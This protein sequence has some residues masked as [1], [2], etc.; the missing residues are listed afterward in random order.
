MPSRCSIQHISIS[1]RPRSGH[2]TE[3]CQSSSQF[4]RQVLLKNVLT[5]RQM[6]SSPTPVRSCL[7]SCILGL[8]IM[9]TKNFQMSKLGLKKEEEPDIKLPTFTGSYINQSNSRKTSISVSSTMLKPSTVWIITNCGKFLKRWEYQPI[10]PVS[11]ETYMQVKKQQLEL[12]ME[13]LIGS[14]LK[15]ESNKAVCCHPVCLTYMLSTWWKMPG[16]MSYKLES[17]YVRESS[18]TSDMQMVPL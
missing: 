11:W 17:R 3:K 4:W 12:R 14:R 18:T 1:R 5:I 16:W 13:Q 10:L 9:Q 7:K 15:K 2:R 8:N 6:H